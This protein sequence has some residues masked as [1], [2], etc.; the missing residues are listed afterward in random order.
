VDGQNVH[1]VRAMLL[2]VTDEELRRGIQ[3]TAGHPRPLGPTRPREVADHSTRSTTE[4]PFEEIELE[5]IGIWRA[6]QDSVCG[7]EGGVDAKIPDGSRSLSE[8]RTGAPGRIRTCDLGLRRPTL[9][10]AE[11]RARAA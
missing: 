8:A 6:R 4:H 11:L 3:V 9:Y 1:H 7:A 10:P 2:N 5:G